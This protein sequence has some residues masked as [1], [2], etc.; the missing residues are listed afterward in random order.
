[1]VGGVN[2]DYKNL[3]FFVYNYNFFKMYLK[4]FLRAFS[5]M[6]QWSTI[7]VSCYHRLLK[8]ESIFGHWI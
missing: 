5:E 6:Y 8:H 4:L 3:T 2:N 1:M 7:E